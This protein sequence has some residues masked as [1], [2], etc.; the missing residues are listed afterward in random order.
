LLLLAKREF[1]ALDA[2]LAEEFRE[3][4]AFHAGPHEVRH[5]VETHVEFAAS[6]E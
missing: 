1:I 5:R 6:I 3:R 2:K 4:C